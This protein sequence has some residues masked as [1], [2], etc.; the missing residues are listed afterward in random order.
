MQDDVHVG[1]QRGEQ[2]VVR[3]VCTHLRDDD[4]PQGD[5]QQHGQ[6]GHGPAMTFTLLFQFRLDH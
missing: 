4:R 3:P 1:G 5:G 2:G 6:H